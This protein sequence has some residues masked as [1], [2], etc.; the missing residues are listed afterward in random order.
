M[1]NDKT[2]PTVITN[3]GDPMNDCPTDW[4]AA[5][6]IAEKMNSRA[7]SGIKWRW[8]CGFKLDYDGGIITISSRFYPPKKHYGPTWDGDAT[9]YFLGDK[10]YEKKFDC[11][12]LEI[13]EKEVTK[14]IK[15]KL[16]I[17]KSRL[18]NP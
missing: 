15:W 14:W 1:Q 2:G 10:L 11:K 5:Q 9:I 12:T 16:E 18:I 6:A 8:D 17:M 3:G 4:D 7:P 13:L